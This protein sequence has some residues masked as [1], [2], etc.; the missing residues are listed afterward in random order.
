MSSLY[1]IKVSDVRAKPKEKKPR[2]EKQIAAFAKAQE[3]RKRK[4]EERESLDKEIKEKHEEIKKV[5]EEIVIASSKKRKT[6]KEKPPPPPPSSP[7]EEDD[8][9]ESVEEKEEEEED[10]PPVVPPV[11]DGI[12]PKWFVEHLEKKKSE[13]SDTKESIA[14]LSKY[15]KKVQTAEAK[16][17]ITIKEQVIAE[18][19]NIPAVPSVG[20]NNGRTG[21][22]NRTTEAPSKVYSQI[23]P[24]RSS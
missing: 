20:N 18:P 15:L 4:R 19:I 7:E 23:F 14:W 3:A 12:P 6:K 16:K 13:K 17:N 2:S 11:D 9:S 8:S 22:D 10:N 21:R 24:G 1:A 5:N